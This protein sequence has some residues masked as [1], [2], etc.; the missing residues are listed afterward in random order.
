MV[1]TW[2]QTETGGICISPRPSDSGAEVKPGMPMRPMFGISPAILDEKVF[3][4]IGNSV[5]CIFF[6]SLLI[7]VSSREKR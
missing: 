1:D 5:S 6:Y 2:W 4:F 7:S 3:I